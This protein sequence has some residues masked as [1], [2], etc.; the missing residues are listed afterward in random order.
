MQKASTKPPE[1]GR[2]T[3]RCTKK[4]LR[5]GSG[6]LSEI[7]AHG[8]GAGG[9][10]D[11]DAVALRIEVA[12]A[13]VVHGYGPSGFRSSATE[14]GTQNTD[15]APQVAQPQRLKATS[16]DRPH[17]APRPPPD[18]P[19]NAEGRREKAEYP[20]TAPTG[21]HGA[22]I[23][24]SSLCILHSHKPPSGHQ[25]GTSGAPAK[26]PHATP[27]PPS[28]LPQATL[29]PPSGYPQATLMRPP[30]VPQATTKRMKKEEGRMPND[31]KRHQRAPITPG[32]CIL[33][34]SF[35]IPVCYLK[36]PG[37]LWTRWQG[38]DLDGRAAANHYLAGDS[39]IVELQQTLLGRGIWSATLP[40]LKA[41]VGRTL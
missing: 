36:A 33:H 29:K 11:G 38:V 9:G 24:H 14:D 13:L 37:D 8:D 40:A 23:R 12:G 22:R 5:K 3:G 2:K 30:C 31:R 1:S 32:F 10:F 34:S 4:S 41:Q 6:R 18:R 7:G 26:H 16:W 39:R 27:K 20:Q 35:C 21:A 17:T 15:S 25:R 19:V 28:S